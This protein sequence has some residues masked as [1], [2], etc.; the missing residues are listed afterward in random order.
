M[1]VENFGRRLRGV[2]RN[3]VAWGAA[4]FTLGFVGIIAMRT[5]GVVVPAWVTWLDALGMSIKIGV[6]GGITGGA[7]AAFISL[8]YRG[9]RL[10]EIDWVRFGIG[11]GIVAGL[12]VP[13]FMVLANLF[14]GDSVPFDAIR[15]DIV[16]ATLFGGV[17]AGAS[18]WLAQRGQ[19][20]PSA[21]DE[22]PELLGSG[23]PFASGGTRDARRREA[24]APRDET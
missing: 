18:M 24:P 13:T 17:T 20:P 21:N 16:M 6:M 12:F 7:F 3:A 14:T 11:G 4:W 10:S 9:R 19:A 15:G 22:E 1:H 23:D 8:F 5:I 2:V